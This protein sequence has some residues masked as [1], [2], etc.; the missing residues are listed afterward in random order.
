MQ[1]TLLVL[2]CQRGKSFLFT[3]TSLN[4]SLNQIKS[5]ASSWKNAAEMY[6]VGYILIKSAN[7]SDCHFLSLF[8]IEW[9]TADT[10]SIEPNQKNDKKK[11]RNDSSGIKANSSI[12]IR[13][14]G[15][16]AQLGWH[17]L[18]K[19]RRLTPAPVIPFPFH[20]SDN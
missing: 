11:Q 9:H 4:T 6:I 12:S 13:S 7:T 20:G 3:T 10:H 8:K 18:A 16:S 2:T 5:V 1:F 15:W 17:H 14:G 19:F